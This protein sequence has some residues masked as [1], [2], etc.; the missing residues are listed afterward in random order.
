M[1]NKK[2]VIGLLALNLRKRN[3]K[4][5]LENSKFSG[6]K[7]VETKVDK[8]IQ[9]MIDNFYKTYKILSVDKLKDELII[10]K[11]EEEKLTLEKKEYIL[12]VLTYNGILDE[13]NQVIKKNKADIKIDINKLILLIDQVSII[14]RNLKSKYNLARPRY[15]AKQLNINLNP[16]LKKHSSSAF[17]S[18][19]STVMYSIAYTLS[20]IN[21]KGKNN[22]LK[23]AEEISYCRVLS[24]VHYPS[25]IY[26]GKILAEEISKI[27]DFD[28][29]NNI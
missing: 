10:M 19:T 1:I 16:Y 3:K 28:L 7:D 8:T 22:Y 18:G 15:L 26:Y 25:D 13:F 4:Y 27:I 20:K 9:D 21:P 12:K 17:P 2:I 5:I 23:K 6:Y 11:A 14:V 29:E 24:G